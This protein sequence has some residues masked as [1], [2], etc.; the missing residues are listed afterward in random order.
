MEVWA[1]ERAN[2]IE[3]FSPVVRMTMVRVVLAFCA[4]YDLHLEQLY[5]KTAFLHGNLE[6][7][8]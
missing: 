2:Y 6:E 8:I 1:L 5:V 7:E 3:I 4:M